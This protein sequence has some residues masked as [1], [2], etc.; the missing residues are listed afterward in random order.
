MNLPAGAITPEPTP[1][2]AVWEEELRVD[3]R[4]LLPGR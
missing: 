2:D 3:Y 4:K 1:L